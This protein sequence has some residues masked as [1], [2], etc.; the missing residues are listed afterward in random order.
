MRL[1]LIAA[2]ASN[3]VIGRGGAL[4]WKI[5]EDLR[6]FKHLTTGRAVL[7]GR[8]TYASLGKPLAHRRNVV[9]STMKIPGVE[10]YRSVDQAL[11]ALKDEE[12]VFVIGGAR[13]YADLLDH[14]DELYL[15]LLDNPA[16]GD[17]FFPPFQHLL[18]SHFRETFREAH[19]GFTFVNYVRLQR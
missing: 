18:A 6:R 15:T 13:L 2:I 19:T 9:V 7:M 16:E 14:A 1:A 12:L 4:P 10:S 8:N 17:T 3:R 11:E 5:P